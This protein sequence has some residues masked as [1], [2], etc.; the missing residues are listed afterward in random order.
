MTVPDV[1]RVAASIEAACVKAGRDPK[2]VRLLA[3]TKQVPTP[4][5]RQA[6][7]LGVSLFGENRVQ[8][9]REKANQGAYEGS[10][11]CLIGHLQSNKASLAARLFDEVHSVDSLRIADALNKASSR[12]RTAPLPV[13]IEVNAGEDPAKFGVLPGSV[14]ELAFAVMEMPGLALRGLMTVA[15]G[16]GDAELARSAFRRLRQARDE[17]RD[18]GIPA[19]SLREL[20]M[21]MSGDYEIAI[22]EGSTIVRIGTALFGPRKAR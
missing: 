19:D 8:E 18:A 4:A 7:D 9:A 16:Y 14:K 10:T 15:P 21:G 12:Y 17:L 2:S 11:L 1:A 22:S 3:V 20:S 5:I 6:A 13:L